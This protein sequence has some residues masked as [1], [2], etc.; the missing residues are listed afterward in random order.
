[1]CEIFLQ[2]HILSTAGDDALKRSLMF[3]V[4]RSAAITK[5]TMKRSRVI[6]RCV[7]RGAYKVYKESNPSRVGVTEGTSSNTNG[8]AGKGSS[9]NR[10]HE[11]HG[12]GSKKPSA[13]KKEIGN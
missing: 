2:R 11:H 13:P 3:W 6:K 4:S 8:K 1:M 7:S 5:S 10:V 9:R 12:V